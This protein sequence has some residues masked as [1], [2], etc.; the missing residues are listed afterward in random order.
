MMLD[1]KML[2]TTTEL[3]R[4]LGIDFKKFKDRSNTKKMMK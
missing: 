2:S 1:K 3:K 4:K